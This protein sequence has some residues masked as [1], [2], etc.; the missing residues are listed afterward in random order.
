LLKIVKI[1]RKFFT[2]SLLINYYTDVG[3]YKAGAMI[4]TKE[5][6]KRLNISQRRLVALIN[7]GKVHGAYK[8][9]NAWVIPLVNGEPVIKES[10]H[11]PAP[12]WKRTKRLPA[13][14]HISVNRQFIG[15]KDIKGDYMPVISVKNGGN[16]KYSSRVVIPGP[17]EV[18]YDYNNKNCSGARIWIESYIKTTSHNEIDGIFLENAM[19]YQEV[20]AMIKAAT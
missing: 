15:Q 7:T 17:C 11:G 12:K 18:I 16:N 8:V 5:A 20:K 9:A 10:N 19:S 2:Q 6:A 14:T 3:L 13:L 1:L 4:G